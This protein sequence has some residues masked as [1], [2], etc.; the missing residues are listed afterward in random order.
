MRDQW[1]ARKETTYR[2]DETDRQKK[3][4]RKRQVGYKGKDGVPLKAQRGESRCG[5][6]SVRWIKK[7]P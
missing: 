7:K 4:P 2:G 1:G 6:G 3:I 5:L